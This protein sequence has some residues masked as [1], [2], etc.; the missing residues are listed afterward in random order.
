[1]KVGELP[2]NPHRRSCPWSRV[3]LT[4]QDV[5]SNPS[6]ALQRPS[7]LTALLFEASNSAPSSASDS[8]SSTEH[9]TATTPLPTQPYVPQR[10][11]CPCSDSVKLVRD[12]TCGMDMDL[13]RWL[14]K[15]AEFGHGHTSPAN[16]NN[17]HD[18][19]L[20]VCSAWKDIVIL[21][22]AQNKFD[23]TVVY[24]AI[25]DYMHHLP[26][27]Q[28]SYVQSYSPLCTTGEQFQGDVFGKTGGVTQTYAHPLRRGSDFGIPTMRTV[29][30]LRFTLSKLRQMQLDSKEYAVLRILLL[31]NSDLHSLKDSRA[32]EKASEKVHT[33]L[34]EY[35][36]L[37]YPDDPLRLSHMLLL[38]PG[39]RGFSAAVFENLFY[40][41]LIGDTSVASVL[42]EL[43][44]R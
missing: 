15:C 14:T 42:R 4:D 43:M 2:F 11:T 29:E 25:R 32:V 22:M 24:A 37:K 23:F 18:R 6:P 17:V 39:V 35:E 12:P 41:H 30:Q 36:T 3:G 7:P 38:L 28:S 8:T 20:L 44:V 21:Y 31:L 34:M 40:H 27:Q 26:Q 13:A 16:I 10:C 5:N 33:A 1:M 19:Q 9:E